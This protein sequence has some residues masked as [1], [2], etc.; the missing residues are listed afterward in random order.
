MFR[1]STLL[2]FALLTSLAAAPPPAATE[3]NP[4][5]HRDL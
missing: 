5:T 1:V 3:V 4:D 2:P